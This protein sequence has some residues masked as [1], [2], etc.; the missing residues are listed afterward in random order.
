MSFPSTDALTAGP[1]VHVGDDLTLQL[2]GLEVEATG[3]EVYQ[4]SFR[5]TPDAAFRDG[6]LRHGGGTSWGLLEG[7]ATDPTTLSLGTPDEVF[8]LA[9]GHEALLPKAVARS[10]P[11]WPSSLHSTLARRRVSGSGTI[12]FDGGWFLSKLT[13]STLERPLLLP[14]GAARLGLSGLVRA[15]EVVAAAATAGGGRD[16]GLVQMLLG[17][18]AC[19]SGVDT[20]HEWGGEGRLIGESTWGDLAQVGADI[21]EGCLAARGTGPL[22]V[23]FEPD[24][25]MGLGFGPR[26]P[27]PAVA[28]GHEPGEGESVGAGAEVGEVEPDGA[29]EDAGVR[30]GM[31]VTEWSSSQRADASLP[32]AFEDFLDAID[33]ERDAGQRLVLTFDTAAPLTHLYAVEM[34]AA[35]ALAALAVSAG[36]LP[37]IGSDA[38]VGASFDGLCG[39]ELLW[40][41]PTPRLFLGASGSVT[42]AHVDICPQ[43]QVAHGLVGTK[44]LGV[45]SQQA[46]PRLSAEHAGDA[47]GAGSA[48]DEGAAHVPMDRP[49]SPRQAR[50]LEDPEVTL[51]LLQ[52]GDLAVFDSGALHF[53]SNGA[54]G[55]AGALYHG[56]ITRPVVP[57]LRRA[58]ASAGGSHAPSDDAYGEHLFAAD[59]LRVVD[60]R[61]ASRAAGSS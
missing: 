20:G 1:L 32:L 61:M 2:L 34:P 23:V 29:A 37:A 6:Q 35:S 3:E 45:A 36:G 5:P 18:L 38:G 22:R 11:H 49:L 40:R 28:M 26:V 13:T 30:P 12:A 52:E 41:E 15:S 42:C 16:D 24:E 7:G 60:E 27:T 47:G 53:A 21:A 43:L 10:A 59:L 51:V 56:V 55:L 19:E 9:L 25:P 14:D 17:A 50:L 31:V 8:T 57:R 58:A 46:T 39:L 44:V 4:V 33:E 54:E 48:I